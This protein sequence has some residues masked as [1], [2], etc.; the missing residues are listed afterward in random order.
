MQ[1][2]ETTQV[3]N[4]LFDRY[5]PLLSE[6]ELRVLLVIIRQTY[7][8]VDKKTGGR[9]VKDRIS[10]GQ[11]MQKSGL[12]RRA[13]SKAVNLLVIKHLIK[14]V[15]VKGRTVEQAHQR[16]G[17]TLLTYSLCFPTQRRQLSR[18]NGVQDIQ[19]ILHSRGYPVRHLVP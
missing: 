2:R 7:G 1:Y 4:I 3:P 6:S 18:I 10:H 13:I 14:V 16:K 15:D 5:F 19:D 9:K 17:A 8:W 12:S 11:F